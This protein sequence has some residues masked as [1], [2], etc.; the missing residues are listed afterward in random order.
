MMKIIEALSEIMMGTAEPNISVQ[1]AYILVERPR[2]FQ[3]HLDEQPE[4]LQKLS[5][6]CR[7]SGRHKVLILGENTKVGLST[8]DLLELGKLQFFDTETAAKEWLAI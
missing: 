5:D 2:D 7:K 3:V 6:I 1:E 8:L 4:L